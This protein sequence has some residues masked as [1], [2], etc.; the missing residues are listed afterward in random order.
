[1]SI[2]FCMTAIGVAHSF[3]FVKSSIHNEKMLRY[4]KDIGILSFH[5][6][7]LS[8]NNAK[9]LDMKLLCAT[10]IF[11]IFTLITIFIDNHLRLV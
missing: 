3:L 4:T 6:N 1:V 9:N 5:K 10:N 11:V 2:S 8:F 7:L